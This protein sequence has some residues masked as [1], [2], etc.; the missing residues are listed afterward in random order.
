MARANWREGMI[1]QR[2][3]LVGIVPI[4][5]TGPGRL[6]RRN[7]G[8]TGADAGWSRFP[9]RRHQRAPSVVDWD[10][11]I[12]AAFS[13]ALVAGLDGC[14]KAPTGSTR[15]VRRNPTTGAIERF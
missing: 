5:A 10:D 6:G 12:L 13:Q 8:R 7:T 1:E 14:L 2:E 11:D 3:H 9:N 15:G 4:I